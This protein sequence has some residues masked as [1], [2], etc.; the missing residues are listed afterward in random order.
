MTLSFPELLLAAL[1]VGG[2]VHHFMRSGG[3]GVTKESRKRLANAIV[4]AGLLALLSSIW[5]LYELNDHGQMT[6]SLT[7]PEALSLIGLQIWA[8]ALFGLGLWL[9]QR[10]PANR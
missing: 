9:Y 8:V 2:L 1:V 5:R 3:K 4:I 10:E 7:R 6:T